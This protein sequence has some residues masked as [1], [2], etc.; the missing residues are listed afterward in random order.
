MAIVYMKWSGW[1][2]LSYL[3]VPFA[4]I[5][6]GGAAFA[7]FPDQIKSSDG[8]VV[9]GGI[10]IG[11]IAVGVAIVGVLLWLIGRLVNRQRRPDGSWVWTNRHRTVNLP[12]H[13]A[14]LGFVG[15]RSYSCRWS[16]SATSVRAGSG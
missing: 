11:G 10:V 15:S 3:L 9:H 4:V 12:L 1:G 7:L 2:I 6:G 13:Q 5:G 14:G 8:D 16:R